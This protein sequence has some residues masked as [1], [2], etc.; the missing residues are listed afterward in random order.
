MSKGDILMPYKYHVQQK[1]E[2]I[3]NSMFPVPINYLAN[4]PLPED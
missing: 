1:A 3:A 2:N 4:S